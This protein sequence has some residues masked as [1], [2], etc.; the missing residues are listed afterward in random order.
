MERIQI[1]QVNYRRYIQINEESTLYGRSKQI[2]KEFCPKVLFLAVILV[3]ATVKYG[4]KERKKLEAFSEWRDKQRAKFPYDS[5]F[6]INMVINL[7]LTG[8][9][10]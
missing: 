1:C 8:V 5:K 6:Q 10:Q 7:S 2:Y 3:E 9:I 4:I